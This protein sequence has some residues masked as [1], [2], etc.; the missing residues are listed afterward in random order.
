[1]LPITSSPWQH[2][3]DVAVLHLVVL[4][5]Y[6]INSPQQLEKPVIGDKVA[7]GENGI[8]IP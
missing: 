8:P 2:H 3:E 5:H 1:M 6:A 7:Y 4:R